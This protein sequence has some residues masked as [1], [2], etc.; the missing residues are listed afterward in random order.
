MSEVPSQAWLESVFE[1]TK[2]WGRWGAEDERGALNFITPQRRRA[3]AAL[4]RDGVAVSCAREL[5]SSRRSRI[6]APRSITCWWRAT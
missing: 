3:A 1:A 4:V 2:N 6:R 5:P